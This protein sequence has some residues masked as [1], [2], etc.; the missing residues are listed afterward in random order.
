MISKKRINRIRTQGY[1]N[2]NDYEISKLAFGN[3]FA[4][5]LCTCVI[6][7]GLVFT[8]KTIIATMMLIAFLGIATSYHPFDHI[9]NYWLRHQLKKPKLP[10]RSNQLKFA[11]SIATLFLASILF[12]FS[13]GYFLAGYIV[14]AVLLTSAITVSAFDF[15]GPSVLYNKFNKK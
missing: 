9:Y 8:S 3:R 15:C 6:I 2:C 10:P 12:L 4:Y 7:I 5:I 1:F 11:C 13:N 14:G